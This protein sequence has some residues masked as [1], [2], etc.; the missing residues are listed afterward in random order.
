M[1]NRV[2]ALAVVVA[3]VLGLGAGAGV[4]AWQ[5][6]ALTPTGTGVAQAASSQGYNG[7]GQAQ[8]GGGANQNFTALSGTVQ[9]VSDKQISVEP[10]SGGT[11]V[12]VT[13]ADSTAITKVDAAKASDVTQGATVV[14]TGQQQGDGIA[15]ATVQIVEGDLTATNPA[16][17]QRLQGGQGAPSAQGTPGAQRWQSAQGAPGGQNSQSSQGGQGFQGAGR[18]GGRVQGK[19]QAVDGQT[20]TVTETNGTT[21]KVVL[22]ASTVVT[23]MA[24]GSAADLKQGVPVMV[25]G[26]AGTDGT[27]AARTIQ[28]Q[29][30]T[31]GH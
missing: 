27:V 11:Y 28:I 6:G 21:T 1:R 8:N 24:Q 26:S 10:Q 31:A 20:L 25:V 19:V 23:K 30:A 7:N 17:G 15:A 13:L 14:V 22:S 29:P 3:I 2:F 9:Q 18:G 16:A 5:R 4:A 12:T